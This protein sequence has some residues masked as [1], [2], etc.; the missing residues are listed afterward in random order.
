[1]FGGSTLEDPAY[2]DWVLDLHRKGFEIAFHGATDHPA[3]RELVKQALDY[4]ENLLEQNPRMYVMHGGQKEALYWGDARL[5]GCA[6][7]VYRLLQCL[8]GGGE[9]FFGHIKGSPYFWGDLCKER[10]TYMR[11][12]VFRGI[13]TLRKDPLMPY[14]DPR[15]PFIRY[16]FSSSEGGNVRNFC[17]LISEDNQDQLI[18]EGGACIVYTHFANGFSDGGHIVGEVKRLIKRLAALPGWFVPASTLLDYLRGQPGHKQAIDARVLQRMQWEW[19]FT[20]L[21]YGRS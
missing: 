8:H 4:F 14:H 20:K 12:Y 10:I 7:C 16:W 9:S 15:R 18:A 2:R 21:R 1:M 11:N 19:L 13:N 6:R 5:D 3:T 17:N